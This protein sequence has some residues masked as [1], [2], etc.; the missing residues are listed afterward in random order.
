MARIFRIL[1]GLTAAFLTISSA[2]ADEGR[3][4]AVPGEGRVAA[5]PD[6]ATV[7]LGVRR[8]DRQ[9]GAAMRAASEAGAAVLAT[10]AEAGVDDGDV[11]TTRIG[12]DPRYQHSND[13]SPPRI[14]GYVAS[15]D[16]VVRVRDLEGLGAILDALV[17]DGANSF[18]GIRFGLSE[19]DEAEAE[20][21]AAAV[22]DALARAETL[23]GAAG[24]TL[25]P[26]MSLDEAG[27]GG[28]VPQP[29]M[30]GAMMEAASVPVAEGEVEVT[31]R[32]TATFAIED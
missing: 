7:S 22:A 32:V 29:I 23:A 30:R 9:A 14:T 2:L 28:P 31:V 6:M 5:R 21:R 25:G 26:L 27:L 11:Q 10:L 20:A 3:L 16:L 12:L 8:E 13:G 15:N 24:V 19:P 17:V 4:I 1:A 18:S